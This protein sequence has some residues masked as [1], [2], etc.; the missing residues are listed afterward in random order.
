MNTVIK[1]NF[2]NV[3]SVLQSVDWFD[4][5]F[6]V[7]KRGL[8]TGP[9]MVESWQYVKFALAIDLDP[10]YTVVPAQVTSSFNS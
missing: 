8:G 5:I 9:S 1:S 2:P 10:V 4:R 7:S 6:F 3:I